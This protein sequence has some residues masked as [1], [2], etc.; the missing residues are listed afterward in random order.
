[1]TTKSTTLATLLAS[2]MTLATGPWALAQQT[3]AVAVDEI[4][5]LGVIEEVAPKPAPSVLQVVGRLHSAAVH[6]PIA[7]LPLLVLVEWL[8]LTGRLVH[9]WLSR[10][11]LAVATLGA[12]VPAA[13]SGLLRLAELPADAPSLMTA[14][15]HRN[16]MLSA[17]GL[18]ATALL[19][20]FKVMRS[21]SPWRYVYLMALV[22][23]TGLVM[24]GAHLGGRLVFGDRFLPF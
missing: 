19:L 12:F 2:A 21:G 11:W 14:H 13:A 4:E 1:M 9:P 3:N 10:P 23:A 18:L 20:R 24:I 16:F 8:V 7:W 17:V 22:I 5:E 15:L 6:F